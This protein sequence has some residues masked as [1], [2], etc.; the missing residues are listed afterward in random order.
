MTRSQVVR[1]DYADVLRAHVPTALALDSAGRPTGRVSYQPLTGDAFRS[2]WQGWDTVI[3]PEVIGGF[4]ALFATKNAS[5]RALAQEFLG[6][7]RDVDLFL[8]R[9]ERSAAFPTASTHDPQY[10]F[11][12]DV[13]DPRTQETVET[14]NLLGEPFHAQIAREASSI[15]MDLPRGVTEGNRPLAQLWRFRKLEPSEHTRE[16]LLEFLVDAANTFLLK[17]CWAVADNLE[18]VL[19]ELAE[20]EQLDLAVAQSMI[21]ESGF[22]YLRQLSAAAIPTIR[23]LILKW[24]TLRYRLEEERQAHQR[25]LRV[26]HGA[27]EDVDRVRAELRE[28]L[29]SNSE[30]ANE[31]LECV[32]SKMQAD[33]QYSLASLLFE[34]FQNSDDA[35]VEAEQM[36]GPD[37]GA[38]ARALVALEY[39]GVAVRWMHWGRLI[40]RYRCP[41]F[42]ADTGRSRGF[43]RDLEKMLVLSSSDKGHGKDVT[44]RF[45]LGFKTVFLLANQ[46]VVLSGRLGFRVVAGMFPK[47]LA[48]DTTSEMQARLRERGS[49]TPG[50]IVELTAADGRSTTE[51]VTRFLSLAHVALAFARRIKQCAIRH[52]DGNQELSWTDRAVG[53]ATSVRLGTLAPSFGAE[54]RPGGAL[55]LG[56][57]TTRLLLS[58]N[59][60]GFAP[61]PEPSP[62]SGS[63]RP[64]S[65]VSIP[66]LRSTGRL[67]STWG[68]LHVASSEANTQAAKTAGAELATAFEELFLSVEDWLGPEVARLDRYRLWDSLWNLMRRVTS[69]A[70]PNRRSFKGA[71]E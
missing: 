43:D 51:A 20:T 31:L 42:A 19:S 64:L 44:G 13:T 7:A 16:Q 8:S 34:L 17:E 10:P 65:T 49:E 6:P 60:N 25:G 61:L 2:F 57:L 21:L 41:T 24:D 52:G 4:L 14:L 22:F 68:G 3:A 26:S 1:S 70:S 53:Q 29:E 35:S 67:R 18:E 71:R 46:P 55:M 37:R 9:I 58:V 62:P 50:T 23:P 59:A 33:Y 63:R 11:V 66:G 15:L 38:A 32:R 40:N 39:D 45:G 12:F 30:A 56:G 28:L 36:D 47:A 69:G 48:A 5:I 27:A 54:A